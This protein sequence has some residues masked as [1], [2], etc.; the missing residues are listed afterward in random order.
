MRR[1]VCQSLIAS[2]DQ[3]K[4]TL[5]SES[6]D[7]EQAIADTIETLRASPEWKTTR[8]ADRAGA[9]AGVRDAANGACI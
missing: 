7:A 6:W 1:T 2:F 5:A 3:D 9:V 4:Q 8:D